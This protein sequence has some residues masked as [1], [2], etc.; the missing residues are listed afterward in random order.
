MIPKKHPYKIGDVV[1]FHNGPYVEF[2]GS[3]P[4]GYYEDHIILCRYLKSNHGVK[5][6]CRTRHHKH[7]RMFKEFEYDKYVRWIPVRWLP[8]LGN[9]K[10]GYV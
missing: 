2:L 10:N 6:V 7:I 3:S 9:T 5:I 4:R 1:K 8:V